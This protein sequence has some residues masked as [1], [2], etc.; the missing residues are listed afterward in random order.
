MVFFKLCLVG[1]VF[2]FLSFKLNKSLQEGLSNN[3]V[4]ILE[5]TLI[6]YLA[7][8]CIPDSLKF[9]SVCVFVYLLNWNVSVATGRA[10]IA[11][12][13]GAPDV[14]GSTFSLQFLCIIMFYSNYFTVYVDHLCFLFNIQAFDVSEMFHC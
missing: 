10:V 12:P 8:T 9:L 11:Y 3:G 2:T 1:K 4:V 7:L 14:T 5:T 13:F 6:L